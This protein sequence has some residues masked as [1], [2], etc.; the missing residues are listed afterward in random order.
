MDILLNF[1]EVFKSEVVP[2]LL[3][4]LAVLIPTICVYLN[5]KLKKEASRTE[6][7]IK[8]LGEVKDREDLRPVVEKLIKTIEAGFAEQKTQTS[9]QAEL[10]NTAFQNSELTPDVKE[11]LNLVTGTVK[12]GKSSEY[13]D[14]LKK[15][16]S[17]KN[18]VISKLNIDIDKIKV[19]P[20]EIKTV[21]EKTHRVRR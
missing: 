9:N 13:I 1:W 15:E 21:V 16:I 8:V 11:T 6:A 5:N 12:Y 18:E 19:I 4:G 2:A 7:H 17:D 14:S 10:F 3:A 20:K